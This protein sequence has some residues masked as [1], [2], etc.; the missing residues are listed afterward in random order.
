MVT[1]A[2]RAWDEALGWP[3]DPMWTESRWSNGIP[4]LEIYQASILARK[5]YSPVDGRR[6]SS[7]EYTIELYELHGSSAVNRG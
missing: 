3:P 2:S 6:Q 1:N 5:A 7:E 4:R